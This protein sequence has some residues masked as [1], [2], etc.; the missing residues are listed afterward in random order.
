VDPTAVTSLPTRRELGADL[1]P[2]LLVVIT[3]AASGA[4]KV[5]RPA[6]VGGR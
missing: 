6:D 4:L 1:L 3:A 5:K 2:A